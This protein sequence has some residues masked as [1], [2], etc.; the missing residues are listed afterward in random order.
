M[1]EVTD[2][3]TIT[4]DYANVVDLDRYPIHDL[5]SE[6]GQAFIQKCRE[7]LEANGACNLPGF[8]KP[9][10]VAAMVKLADDLES[11]AWTSSQPHTIYFEEPDSNVAPDHPRAH[12]VRSVKHGIAYDYIPADAPMRRLYESDDLTDF[13]A[14]VLQKPQLYRSAD[15][16]DAL[17]VTRMGPGDELGW[18][19]DGSEF[20]ITVM[21]QPAEKGGEF[22]Y[23]PAIRAAD[24]EN[25]PTVQR[26]LEGDRTGEHI[27]PGS[28][29]TLA[30]FHGRNALHRVTPVE[31][32]TPR[33]NTVLTYGEHPD[34]KLND[35][36]SEI[37]Y[38]RT[39]S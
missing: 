27:L 32:D 16:L 5:D 7:D 12:Q 14:A 15:P 28:P 1:T 18:H 17:Q 35:L 30:F 6:R 10:A 37:F 2:P 24:D 4:P 8:I 13:I 22:I 36:T 39:S 3:T 21:Y 34:M 23:F 26:A 11:K 20:S 33:I 38:G 19:F 29:G 9:E 31:G 25:Y